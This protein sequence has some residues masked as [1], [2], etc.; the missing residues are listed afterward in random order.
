MNLNRVFKALAVAAVLAIMPRSASAAGEAVYSKGHSTWTAVGF[1]C[2]SGTAGGIIT[3]TLTAVDATQYQGDSAFFLWAKLPT[4]A[5]ITN[6]ILRWGSSASAY[7]AKTITTQA[8]G[9]AFTDGWNLL[10]FDWS[11]Q[12]STG[13]P[14]VSALD[15]F[16]IRFTYNGTLTEGVIVD[17]L[18]MARGR[19][20]DA[21]YYSKYPW[22]TAAGTWELTASADDSILNADE[23]AVDLMVCKATINAA[24]IVREVQADLPI[25]RAR[26]YGT[27]GKDVGL[28]MQYITKYPSQAKL[29][30]SKWYDD[31]SER[32]ASMHENEVIRHS[33]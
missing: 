10:R 27:G 32:G 9:R 23:D 14:T 25:Y 29:M 28:K 24:A 7:W 17:S 22:R 26:Y 2:S 16:L 4:A 13:S 20:V 30:T 31:D 19:D 3:S 18:F 1:Q 12:T 15:S 8:D 33:R 11:T 21:I 5:N 6:V